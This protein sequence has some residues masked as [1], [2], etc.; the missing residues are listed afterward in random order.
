MGWLYALKKDYLKAVG[1]LKQSISVINIG[2]FVMIGD[3]SLLPRNYN[4][5]RICY[6][7]LKQPVAAR[8]CLDS[9]IAI[10]LRLNA[11][12][13]MVV[14]LLYTRS[15]VFFD[16]ADYYRAWE[17]AELGEQLVRENQTVDYAAY[18]SFSY[19]VLK[20]NSLIFLKKYGEV[21]KMIVD[22]IAEN[23]SNGNERS[24]GALYALYARVVE[25]KGDI[26][27]ALKL[28]EQAYYY[29]DKIRNLIGCAEVLNNIGF[30]LYFRMLGQNDIALNYYYQA[31]SDASSREKVNILTNIANAYVAKNNFDSA[32][33]FYQK[34]LNQIIPGISEQDLVNNI[35]TLLNN[36]IIEYIS[37][38]FL[39]KADAYFK[40]YKK[41]NKPEALSMA[42]RAYRLC[43]QLFNTIRRTQSEN[44]SKLFWRV[45]NRRLYDHAI[46]ASYL[47][48][49]PENAFYFFE[50]SRAVLL[51]DQ[52]N[53]QNLVRPTEMMAL[54]QVKRN[55]HALEVESTS[56]NKSAERTAEIQK[57]LFSNRQD[58][59]KLLATIKSTNPLF[60]QGFFDTSLISIADVQQRI[61]NKNSALIEL[62]AGDSTV[63]SLVI[64]S[65]TVQFNKIN[66]QNFDSLSNL[67]I[68]YTSSYSH[69]NANFKDYINVS[70][71]LYHLLFGNIPLVPARIIVS[72]D[73][74]FFPFEAL[75]TSI[76]NNGPKYFLEDHAV[77]YTYSARYL[78]NQFSE[79]DLAFKNFLGLAP[80]RFPYNPNLPDLTGS[81]ES[82]IK[83]E[84][85]FNNPD[86]LVATKAS[87]Y[88]FMH[89]YSDYKIV[90]LYTH[91]SDTSSRG[92][93]VIWF[94]DSVLYLSDLISE[95][96]PLTRL[97]VLS[98]CQTAAGRLYQGE[99]VFS[100][101]RGFAAL[102]IPSAVTNLWSVD[103][104]ST[105]ELT[106]LFYKYLADGEPTD[107]A[108][109]KA[110]LEFIK[111]NPESLPYHWAAP[112]LTGKAEIIELKKSV[113]WIWIIAGIF[114]VSLLCIVWVKRSRATR[115][116]A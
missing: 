29:H 93:P 19:P 21:E 41:K 36:K 14:S 48:G 115:I 90:Q 50:R 82:L 2:G 17:G 54:A 111:L 104:K 3:R 103:S 75:I 42:I 68:N 71:Q 11:A 73:G 94:S 67:F 105:Y 70:N 91:A 32:F 81:D 6:D 33:I 102:G 116:A 97:I 83:I 107:I 7:Y 52:L 86:K 31:L 100:F 38:L 25:A 76:S 62:F 5:L 44:Q 8:A 59:D 16:N 98:A 4:N 66:K 47:A 88:Y 35:D 43:D 95:K 15:N 23:K 37:G 79:A 61:L 26:K 60:Y 80:L 78:L 106:E 30:N 46:E 58:Q 64:T 92:E 84:D 77:T 109:Q 99:G 28:Y 53:E 55:I 89:C 51:N 1:F 9:C 13:S 24:L 56:L 108:L 96:L 12:Q 57:E 34:A 112:I 72:P 69:Q 10:G 101:N 18:Y 87:R 110:K 20:M 49:S 114:I 65:G 27:G 63:F 22:L 85:Y 113:N 45:N 40:Q 74:H 39:D